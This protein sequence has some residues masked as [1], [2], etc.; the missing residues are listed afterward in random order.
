M[1]ML[2]KQFH[3]TLSF[4][5]AIYDEKFLQEFIKKTRLHMT[6]GEKKVMQQEKFDSWVDEWER[7]NQ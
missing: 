7:K 4:I 3:E 6:F 2:K 1:W 5:L